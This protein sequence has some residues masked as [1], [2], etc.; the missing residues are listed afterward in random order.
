MLEDGDSVEVQ[1]STSTYTLSRQGNVFMCTCP[2]W[3]NQGAP[4][5]ARTCKHLRKH[6]GDAFETSRVGA[7]APQRSAATVK[8][9]K[10]AAEGKA[11]PV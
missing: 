10:D 3:R 8:K 11:P 9:D 1:G 6:L 4:V 2:A 5:D 7:A